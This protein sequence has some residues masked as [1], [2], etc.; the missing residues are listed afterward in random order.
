MS[1][2]EHRLAALR[3]RTDEVPPV[4]DA[5]IA[6]VRSAAGAEV[7]TATPTGAPATSV[8]RR[9]GRPAALIGAC[10]A[11]VVVGGLALGDGLPFGLPQRVQQELD[12]RGMVVVATVRDG[13]A[14]VVLAPAADHPDRICLTL[15]HRGGPT[16]VSP[17]LCQR[18]DRTDDPGFD[19]AEQA[20]GQEGWMLHVR[21][22]NP[23]DPRSAIVTEQ[24]IPVGGGPVTIDSGGRAITHHYPHLAERD[25]GPQSVLRP[26]P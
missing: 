23:D 19:F 18:R 12:T 15:A 7:A 22:P 5:V 3:P 9:W 25:R 8:R 1:D 2:L 4:P 10:T 24:T 16:D 13:R 11:L 21:L 17:I 14:Q 26:S 20:P 6:T